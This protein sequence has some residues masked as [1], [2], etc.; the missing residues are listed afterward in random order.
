MKTSV[1][2]IIRLKSGEIA[3]GR[4]TGRSGQRVWTICKGGIE[5]G[6]TYIQTAIREL[7][8]E[9]GVDLN[10]NAQLLKELN[11]EI[12]HEYIMPDKRVILYLLDDQQGILDNFNFY[13]RSN[14]LDKNGRSLPE[15]CEFR[16]FDL[17]D[18][19]DYL[20]NSQHGVIEKLIEYDKHIR[21]NG[22][23]YSNASNA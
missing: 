11:T 21:I 23:S 5:L 8:E 9:S 17:V 10:K 2:I 20:M 18:L 19:K 4:T 6:E 15:I 13:C 16:A 12:F 22:A 3:L 7:E 14:F 1:G